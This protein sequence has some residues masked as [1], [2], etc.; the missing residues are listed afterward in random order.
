MTPFELIMVAFGSINAIGIPII[1]IL[2]R[3]AQEQ[4]TWMTKKLE[5][6]DECIDLMRNQ[7]ITKTATREDFSSFRIEMNETTSRI[8]EAISVEMTRM[9][10]RVIRLEDPFFGGRR[11]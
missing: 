8:R 11:T 7:V 2:M 9:D 1:G 10:Q 5:H 3:N 4:R 6:L